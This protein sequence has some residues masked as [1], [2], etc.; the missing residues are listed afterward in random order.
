[1]AEREEL[2]SAF[3]AQARLLGAE[4][5]RASSPGEARALVKEIIE[6]TGVRRVALASSPL[7]ASLDLIP[8]IEA[9]GA[10]LVK[11]SLREQAETAEMGITAFELAVAETGTLVHDATELDTRLFSMLPLVH[12]ALVPVRG[13]VANLEEALN[14]WLTRGEIP[15]YLAFVSGPSRTADIERV[16]TVGVHGPGRLLIVLLGEEEVCSHE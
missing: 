14:Y 7:L 4:V 6:S 5:Y 13:L 16:L 3:S 9:A 12:L 15:G 10:E 2:I 8:V 1:M 11:G